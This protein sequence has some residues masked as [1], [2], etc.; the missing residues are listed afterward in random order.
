MRILIPRPQAKAESLAKAI[1][2]VHGTAY[3]AP[4]ITIVANK[5]SPTQ[6]S[7][8]HWWLFTSTH[9]IHYS[10]PYW[11]RQLPENLKIATVGYRSAQTL[12]KFMDSRYLV[13][14]A[15]NSEAL[16]ARP[17]LQNV[18]GQNIA[19]IAGK[20]GRRVLSRRLNA[21]GARVTK[22]AFYER[23][24]QKVNWLTK[25]HCLSKRHINVVVA[26][27]GDCLRALMSQLTLTEQQ[28]LQQQTVIAFS[29]RIAN[30]A[31]KLGFSRPPMITSSNDNQ[32]IL[33]CLTETAKGAK[34]G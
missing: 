24:L 6:L 33:Q 7:G 4:V 21:R 3:I 18:N 26:T 9:A 28:Y 20:G 2:Q 25:A 32:A 29:G 13:T 14:H 15:D 5:P 30:I 10:K 34:H 23:C 8:Y 11:P 17:E 31:K 1:E 12:T 16:L 19:L 27:S 22:L